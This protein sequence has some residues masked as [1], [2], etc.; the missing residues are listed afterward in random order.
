M[1]S[2]FPRTSG[3]GGA[4][5]AAVATDVNSLAFPGIQ[6]NG[7]C[8]QPVSDAKLVDTFG[9]P[10]SGG[11]RHEGI[12]IFADSGT[13]IHAISGG[14][15]VQG[16]EGGNLG[17]VVVRIQG[18]DGRYY[19]YAHLKE[20]SVDHLEVGQRINAGEVIGQV[21]NTGNAATTPA[22]LH[23]QVREDGEWINP[24]KFIKDLPDVEDIVGGAAPGPS[25]LA[26]PFAIDRGAPPSVAD[27]DSDGLTD[28]FEQMFGTSVTDVDSDD[29][30]LS[31]SY[32]TA[33]SHTDPLSVD[34]D[35]DG[36]TD[37][38]EL[39]RGTDAG[40]G[41]IPEAARAAGFGGLSSLDSDSDG[42]SDAYEGKRGMNATSA[43]SD[44]DGVGDALE[45][46]R[47]TNPMSAD[48]DNDGLTDGFEN[49]AGTLEPVPS[50][51]GSAAGGGT[52]I[53]GTGALGDDAVPGGGLPGGDPNDPL[54]GGG[55]G[56]GTDY[57]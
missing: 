36:L 19:Y 42:L 30:G 48:S 45:V 14:T 21:G 56:G 28:P 39:A 25:Q 13:P 34:T 24:F 57:P 46:A 27:T 55:A 12:D 29:D 2:A 54:A 32:E 11:R 44:A 40:R 17:G 43:D 4:F 49:A 16:F 51:P 47:G 38:T 50:V 8:C 15:V 33:T 53:P 31:D 6:H 52:P 23:F 20:G 18:D 9:A 10:R 37:A 22:H 7:P 26:D 3:T 41:A 35:R 1:V 5:G